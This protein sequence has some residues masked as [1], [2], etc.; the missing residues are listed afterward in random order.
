MYALHTRCFERQKTTIIAL[1]LTSYTQFI[2]YSIKKEKD[3]KNK[4]KEEEEEEEEN[5]D[6]ERRNLYAKSD[7][8]FMHLVDFNRIKNT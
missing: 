8:S 3:L 7:I 4:R 5:Q 2:I 6:R 1:Y